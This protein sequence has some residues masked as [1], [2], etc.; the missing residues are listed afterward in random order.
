MSTEE[1]YT[2]REQTLVKHFILEKYLERFAHIIG[3]HWDTITYVDCFSGPWNVQSDNLEDSSFYIATNQ[4]RR[5]KATYAKRR[6]EVN[7]RCFFLEKKKAAYAKLKQFADATAD[8]TIET[9]NAAFEDSIMEILDF[10]NKGGAKAFT[11]LFIDPTGWT[12]F[13]LDKIERLLQAE[14]SEALLTFM[15]GFARRFVKSPVEGIQSSFESPFGKGFSLG[16]FEDLSGIDLDDALAATCCKAVA[17]I[18]GF[19]YVRTAIVLHPQINKTY[20]HLIYATRHARGVEVFKDVEKR[21][22]TVMEAARAG[23][24]QRKREQKDGPEFDFAREALH[25]PSYYEF[26]R[27]H[28][29]GRAQDRVR[30]LLHSLTPVSYDDAWDTAL[31]EPLVWESDLKDWIKQWEETLQVRIEGRKPGERTPKREHGH[32][33]VWQQGIRT[34]KKL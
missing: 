8:V 15:T 9:R 30:K 24:Q 23:A 1:F 4:L 10:V 20:F 22:M 16:E 17:K 21:A 27:K 6:R 13:S 31:Q 11:F 25:D 26:L 12:S 19:K 7:L 14:P 33:L 2:G 5:A 32:Y 28:Y 18:G 29:I 34:G 3:S